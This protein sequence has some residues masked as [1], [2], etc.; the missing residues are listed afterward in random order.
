MVPIAELK[1]NHIAWY[2]HPFIWNKLAHRATDF[3]GKLTLSQ[4]NPA[5]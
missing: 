1:K 2:H 4:P 3:L 5:H